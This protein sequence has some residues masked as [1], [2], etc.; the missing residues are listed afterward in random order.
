M[1]QLPSNT[2]LF[3]NLFMRSENLAMSLG[4]QDGAV[5]ILRIPL[6][7]DIPI[8]DGPDDMCFVRSPKLHF[9]FVTPTRFRVLEKKIESSSARLWPL[10][11]FQ[12][13]ISQAEYRW[14]F[15][16]PVLH[17]AFIKSRMILEVDPFVPDVFRGVIL[18]R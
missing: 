8:F 6:T 3:L 12:N 11:I 15:S 14:V 17:P 7:L 16:D 18:I 5:I 10:L 13:D 2:K 4:H 9:H 1:S